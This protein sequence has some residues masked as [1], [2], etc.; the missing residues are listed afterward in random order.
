[1]L[2]IGTKVFIKKLYKEDRPETQQQRRRG[3]SFIECE[4]GYIVD[5]ADN[6]YYL[7]AHEADVT[8]HEDEVEEYGVYIHE[9]E[10]VNMD[11]KKI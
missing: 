8:Y 1:M 2:N 7:V 9:D 3:L 4:Y 11:M 10:L 6:G 5:C